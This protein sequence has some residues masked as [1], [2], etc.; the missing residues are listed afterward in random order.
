MK[1]IH[2]IA[3]CQKVRRQFRANGQTVAL[4]PTMGALHRGHLHLVEFASQYAQQVVVS[5]FVNPLQF[6][7]NEDLGRYP[8]D[9]DGD[10][11]KLTGLDPAVVFAPTVQEM[12]PTQE[13]VTRVMVNEMSQ[14][15]CGRSRPTHFVGVTTVV[16]KLL[17]IVQPEMAFFGEKD[18][19]QLAIIR[20]MV[21][22]LNMPVR[23]LGVPT[24]REESGL[25]LSSRNQ[26]L[27]PSERAI[28]PEIQISLRRAQSLF[29][30][31]ERRRDTLR[32]E[33]LKHLASQ[34]LSPEYVE[35]V[36]PITLRESP[37]VLDG[38]TLL[39]VAVPIGRARL[40]DNTLLRQDLA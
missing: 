20:R 31:G 13:M 38:T 11:Q 14:V 4:V 12:Y 30:W 34:G 37:A 8:R 3:D 32:A 19:Q 35:L 27:D 1:I 18:W 28:A 10:I 24:V 17:N 23:I 5:I 6:G 26:Y 16:N 36:D 29:E 25:A 40:I 15:L 22:D 9:L 39:A 7:P 2:S 21:E 33:V